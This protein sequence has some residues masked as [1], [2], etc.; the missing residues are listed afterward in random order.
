MAENY[1]VKHRAHLSQKLQIDHYE[2]GSVDVIWVVEKDLVHQD[3]FLHLGRGCRPIA[4]VQRVVHSLG[5]VNGRMEGHVRALKLAACRMSTYAVMVHLPSQS[6]DDYEYQYVGEIHAGLN[7]RKQPPILRL[8]Q[9]G[10]SSHGHN[11]VESSSNHK[12]VR[13]HETLQLLADPAN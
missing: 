12:H 5:L 6:P 13:S 4:V 8:E 7:D 1:K 3:E 2:R 10:H 9:N 11:Q